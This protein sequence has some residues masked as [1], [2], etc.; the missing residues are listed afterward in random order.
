MPISDFLIASWYIAALGAAISIAGGIYFVLS[1][2]TMSKS[3]KRCM[4]YIF[5]A[6]FIWIIYS[7]AMIF[8][9]VLEL[10]ITNKLWIVVPIGYLFAAIFYFIGTSRLMKFFRISEN[11][12]KKIKIKGKK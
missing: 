4:F 3:I 8:F 10:E 5:L 7:I 9:S 1:M 2:R 12:C 11:I 6:S